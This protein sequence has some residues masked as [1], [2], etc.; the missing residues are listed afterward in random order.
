MKP[1]ASWLIAAALALSATLYTAPAAAAQ[2]DTEV[3]AAV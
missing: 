2:R 3:E 1:R